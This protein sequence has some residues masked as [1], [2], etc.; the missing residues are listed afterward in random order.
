MWSNTPVYNISSI[1]A[2]LGTMRKIDSFHEGYLVDG[3]IIMSGAPYVS[4]W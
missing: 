3:Y 4:I 2:H 1:L